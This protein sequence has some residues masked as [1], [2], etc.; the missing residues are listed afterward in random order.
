MPILV[1]RH[2]QSRILLAFVPPHTSDL[3]SLLDFNPDNMSNNSDEEEEE[4]EEQDDAMLAKI[5][6][7]REQIK[8]REENM[9]KSY[10]NKKLLLLCG[11][12][13]FLQKQMQSY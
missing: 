9:K 7:Y 11:Q 6:A 2:P 10:P 5:K 12:Y 3:A 1:N 8:K 4:K 13:D